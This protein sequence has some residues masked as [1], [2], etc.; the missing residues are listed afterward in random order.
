MSKAMP[1]F[2]MLLI[3]ALFILS[4]YIPVAIQKQL[5]AV[6]IFIQSGIILLLPLLIFTLLFKTTVQLADRA[7]YVICYLIIA[8]CCSNFISTWISR[9]I[10]LWVHGQEIAF[11][12]PVSGLGLSPAWTL[13]FPRG[14]PNN[15]AMFFGIILGLIGAWRYP[16]RS[17]NISSTL[18]KYISIA[19]RSFNYVIPL[20]IAGFIVKLQHDGMVDM[21]I[22]DYT[23]IFTII[24]VSQFSYISFLYF[25]G[26]NGNFTAMRASIRE[27]LPAALTGFSTMSSAAAMPL[28]IVAAEKNSQNPDF[29]RAAIPATVNIHLIGDCFAI[30]ILA[31]AILKGYGCI[32]P[33]FEAYLLFSI[34]FVLAKFSVAGIPGGGIIVMLPILTQYLGFHGEMLALITALYILFDP[35]ITSANVFGNGAF[36]KITEKLF[37]FRRRDAF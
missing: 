36:A 6:S 16:L 2:L 12:M 18:E 3:A 10:G 15:W 20:F 30:P 23:K 1:F 14:I 28:T 9:L 17:K 32:A 24:A 35:I 34:Y 4:P 25:I 22:H 37:F 29:A 13:C 7:T 26:S 31:H 19:L 11:V 27:V 21:L 5:Y 8:V 33:N